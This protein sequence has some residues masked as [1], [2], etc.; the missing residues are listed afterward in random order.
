MYKSLTLRKHREIPDISLGNNNSWSSLTFLNT[1]CSEILFGSYDRDFITRCHTGTEKIKNPYSPVIR[2]IV[3]TALP[4]SF[5]AAALVPTATARRNDPVSLYCKFFNVITYVFGLYDT[6]K[7][8]GNK[9]FPLV[10]TTGLSVA[11]SH[12]LITLS[13]LAL[14]TFVSLIYRK[15]VT[16]FCPAGILIVFH[17]KSKL[18][19]LTPSTFCF[20]GTTLNWAVAKK[21]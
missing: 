19:S 18:P 12:W 8:P 7:R 3:M 16:I 11:K 4:F 10:T 20:F 1:D 9:S 2:E 15:A 6:K 17:S 5:T 13:S 14:S 21:S